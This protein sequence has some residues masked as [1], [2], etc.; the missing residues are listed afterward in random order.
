[1]R[2]SIRPLK[3]NYERM[4]KFSLFLFLCFLGLVGLA[5]EADSP[6]Q[7][8]PAPVKADSPR[9]AAP[10]PVEADSPRQAAPAPVE[11]DS[12]RQ[13][14]P[15]PVKADSPRQA[16]VPA[17]VNR[18][19]TP[20]RPVERLSPADSLRQAEARR[21][22]ADSIREAGEIAAALR[23][24]AVVHQILAD[25]PYY[26]FKGEPVSLV[27]EM[28]R[29]ESDDADFYFITA[30]IL[31]LA[32]IR[33]AFYRYV[34]AMFTLFF[35]ASMRHQQLREQMLQAPLP[36]FLMNIFFVVS[37]AAYCTFLTGHFNK[38]IADT[39]GS[40]V[41]S[42]AT[43]IALIYIGKFLLLKA[44]GWVFNI[45][46]AADGYIFIVFLVNKVLGVFLLPVLVLLA[47]PT[48]FLYP[49]VLAGSYG[50]VAGMFAYRHLIAYKP[51]RT[52]IKLSRFHFFL[53]LCAFEI[54]PLLLI[55]KVL[56]EFVY[57]I[58]NV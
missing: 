35:R 47:F 19:T 11:A 29:V 4:K 43:L 46:T 14:A 55:Y 58:F 6:R 1:M 18:T 16:A 10:A 26:N 42:F 39:F 57:S 30:L 40:S 5:Q 53:Y 36:A 34:N 54:A 23:L 28:R 22:A 44:A 17:P 7:A 52:E 25:H 45:R 15:T 3:N 21:R 38:P 20:S 24:Q 56:L 12:P 33:L 8:A 32:L 50:L 2:S 27:I 37:L 13:A 49:V 9:Q 51:L 41:V 48:P 31:F